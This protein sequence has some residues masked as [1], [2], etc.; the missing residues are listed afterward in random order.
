MGYNIKLFDETIYLSHV[1]IRS[2]RLK[3]FLK[4]NIT[5]QSVVEKRFSFNEK[6]EFMKRIIKHVVIV[7]F[8]LLNEY[9]LYSEKSF[10]RKLSLNDLFLNIPNNLGIQT[11]PRKSLYMNYFFLTMYLLQV[12]KRYL[13][14]EEDFIYNC[15]KVLQCIKDAQKGGYIA[16]SVNKVD[17]DSMIVQD[18]LIY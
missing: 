7:T 4:N 17:F 13:Y 15:N 1:F 9:Y 2:T 3:E 12:E 14:E 5:I 10:E 16:V 11:M 8:R 6:S 18:L